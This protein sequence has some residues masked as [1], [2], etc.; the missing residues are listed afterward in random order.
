MSEGERLWLG[1]SDAHSDYS[2]SYPVPDIDI[3]KCS[4]TFKHMRNSW[5]CV[6]M[7]ISRALEKIAMGTT[8]VCLT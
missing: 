7:T 4:L 1:N 8:S 5:E 3:A 2:L 6:A